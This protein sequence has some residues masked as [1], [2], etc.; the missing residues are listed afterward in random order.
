MLAV[1]SCLVILVNN[2]AISQNGFL[3]ELTYNF[4]ISSGTI[5][6]SSRS[7]GKRSNLLS[8]FSRNYLQS[9]PLKVNVGSDNL[10]ILR[11]T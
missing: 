1:D 6:G 9:C 7:S 5:V 8:C 10:N 11:K 3:K 2:Q 4:V